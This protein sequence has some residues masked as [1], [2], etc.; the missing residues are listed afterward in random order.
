MKSDERKS[1][2]RITLDDSRDADQ[3]NQHEDDVEEQQKEGE[4]IG[5]FT[6]PQGLSVRAWCQILMSCVL[7]QYQTKLQ[8]S[9][10]Y[11]VVSNWIF[12]YGIYKHLT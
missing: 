2:G 6:T 1:Q 7:V 11:L 5:K 10:F 12:G 9:Y 3:T 4:F 8:I